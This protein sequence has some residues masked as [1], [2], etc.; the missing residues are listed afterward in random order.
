MDNQQRKTVKIIKSSIE[1]L[2]TVQNKLNAINKDTCTDKTLHVID[3]AY[4][5]VD[6]ALRF[7]EHINTDYFTSLH[8]GEDIRLGFEQQNK[9]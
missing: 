7:L 1:E 4:E 5:S 2:K 8:N 6:M 9:Q 3:N